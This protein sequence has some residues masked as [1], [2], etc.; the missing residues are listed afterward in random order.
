VTRDPR[1]AI[2]L[3]GSYQGAASD[4]LDMKVEV[5]VAPSG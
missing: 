3:Q 4:F 5:K 1:Q 2:P